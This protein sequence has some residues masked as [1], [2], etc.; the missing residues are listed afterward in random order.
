MA[1]QGF[2]EV[3]RPA[4]SIAGLCSRFE[5]RLNQA[6]SRPS[7]P[8]RIG[9]THRRALGKSRHRQARCS[10]RQKSSDGACEWSTRQSRNTFV[11]R[12]A[13]RPPHEKG[14]LPGEIGE[15]GPEDEVSASGPGASGDRRAR[16]KT[17]TTIA[18]YGV[19]STE[20]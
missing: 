3:G 19:P 11:F 9:P 2:G 12:G 10:S 4:P 1:W 17:R 5:P 8:A 14:R 15:G 16:A 18:Q 7:H 6:A 20:T 13:L